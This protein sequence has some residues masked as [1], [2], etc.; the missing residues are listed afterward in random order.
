MVP[1]VEICTVKFLTLILIMWL[2]METVTN[3]CYQSTTKDKL[4]ESPKFNPLHYNPNKGS[5][6]KYAI[7]YFTEYLVGVIAARKKR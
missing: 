1:V 4:V 5:N 3:Y 2:V 6:I 7:K